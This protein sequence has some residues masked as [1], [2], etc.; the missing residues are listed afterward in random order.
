LKQGVYGWQSPKYGIPGSRQLSGKAPATREAGNRHACRFGFRDLVYGPRVL[1]GIAKTIADVFCVRSAILNGFHADFGLGTHMSPKA[2]Y[3]LS[4]E[5]VLICL[6]RNPYR[7]L[8]RRWNW[9]SAWLSACFRG[10]A[11]L[12][13]NL[14]GGVSNA[15]GA[16]LAEVGYRALTS[17]FYSAA[18]QAFRY[19]R[20]AWSASLTSMVLIPLVA[21]TL[22]YLMHRFR[23]TPRLG[24]T[25]AASLIVT[26][27][28]TLFELFAMRHGF[29]IIGQ[30]SG[31]LVQDIKRLPELILILGKGCVGALQKILKE[32][33][34]KLAYRTRI[35]KAPIVF[36]N[37]RAPLDIRVNPSDRPS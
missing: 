32:T 15:L 10:G 5:K 11:V 30:N 2:H 21:D 24:A 3:G 12:V 13:V 9:K 7:H 18:I 26:A 34:T 1:I 16:M 36:V 28:S 31:S 23:D 37:F 22:E 25:I 19:S 35:P 27:V 14:S 4:V 33:R 29:F 6:A 20:P 8:I 17:G